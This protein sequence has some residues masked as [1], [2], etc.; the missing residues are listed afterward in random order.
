MV[1]SMNELQERP[2]DTARKEPSWT[3][4]YNI[5]SPESRRWIG[6][7]WEFFDSHTDAEKCVERL[8]KAG[9]VAMMRPFH[10][11]DRPHLGAAHRM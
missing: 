1:A 4:L 3:V 2:A 11:N 6:T 10:P 9:D 5:V 7:G 8:T